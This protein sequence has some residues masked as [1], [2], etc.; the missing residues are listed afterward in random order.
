MDST[1]LWAGG[2]GLYKKVANCVNSV[3]LC[4][5]VTGIFDPTILLDCEMSFL[6]GGNA[7]WIN[8]QSASKFLP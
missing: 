2:P 8:K 3:N 1:V 4:E 5:S 6:V 7:V